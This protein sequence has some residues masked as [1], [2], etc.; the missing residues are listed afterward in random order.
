MKR[1]ATVTE[2]VTYHIEFDVP[3]DADNDLVEE[4][5]HDEWESC[6]WRKPDDYECD[7]EVKEQ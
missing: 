3:D 2:T 1:K 7:I 5:A 6:N 4:L